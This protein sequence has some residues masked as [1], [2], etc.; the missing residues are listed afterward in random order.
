MNCAGLKLRWRFRSGTEIC[1]MSV[2]RWLPMGR[3]HLSRGTKRSGRF[4]IRCGEPR[5]ARV[6]NPF[7]ELTSARNDAAKVEAGGIFGVIT[8]RLIART[9]ARKLSGAQMDKA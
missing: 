6:L 3:L 8:Y 5:C 2:S 4:V 9:A 7:R 1:S